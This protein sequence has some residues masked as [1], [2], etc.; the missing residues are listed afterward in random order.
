[1]AKPLV[2]NEIQVGDI[3]RV[4]RIV[5]PT[6]GIVKKIEK[7]SNLGMVVVAPHWDYECWGWNKGLLYHIDF[8]G[9]IKVMTEDLWNWHYKNGHGPYD[10]CAVGQEMW[11]PAKAI[12]KY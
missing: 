9:V 2:F 3:V 11:V 10:K 7:A 6:V 1:M 8:G 12:K 4:F 5:D